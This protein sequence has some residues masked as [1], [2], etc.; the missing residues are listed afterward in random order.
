M[1]GFRTHTQFQSELL[2]GVERHIL[3]HVTS[4][5]KKS[6]VHW[7]GS[8]DNNKEM[9]PMGLITAIPPNSSY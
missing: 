2:W 6:P 5:I 1:N 4:Q 7:Q 8:L 3:S 9:T